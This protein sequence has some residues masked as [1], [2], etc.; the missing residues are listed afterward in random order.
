MLHTEISG[1]IPDIIRNDEELYEENLVHYFQVLFFK[2]GNLTNPYHNLRHTL[3]VLWLCY[4]A[5]RYYRD[6][7]TPRQM[8]ILLIAALFHDFDHPGQPHPGEAD[9][10]RINIDIALDQRDLH[11]RINNDGPDVNQAISEAA[12][13]TGLGLRVTRERL[14]ALYGKDQSL[15]I[16]ARPEGGAEVAIRIPFRV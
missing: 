14:Q 13:M 10:D 8:R 16:Q 1:D 7:L 6:E 5:C 4:K 9:P 3:H 12:S 11:I 2:A 15:H